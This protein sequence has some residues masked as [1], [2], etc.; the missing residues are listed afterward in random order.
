MNYQWTE[1]GFEP[2]QLGGTSID[3]RRVWL[4]FAG[5][6]AGCAVGG[7]GLGVL[8]AAAVSKRVFDEVLL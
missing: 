1:Q 6:V 5:V 4:R 2:V 7:F 8:I 3:V